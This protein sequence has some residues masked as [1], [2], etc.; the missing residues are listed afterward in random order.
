[1]TGI[2]KVNTTIMLIKELNTSKFKKTKVI[3]KVAV[4]IATPKP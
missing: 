1:M 3:I 2:S 4:A